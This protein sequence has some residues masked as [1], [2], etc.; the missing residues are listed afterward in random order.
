MIFFL[1]LS[2]QESKEDSTGNPSQEPSAE[3]SSVGDTGVEDTGFADTGL[4]DTGEEDTGEED[5]SGEDASLPGCDGIVGSGKEYDD[6]GVCG[7]ESSACHVATVLGRVTPADFDSDNDIYECMDEN[8]SDSWFACNRD[9]QYDGC[10]VPGR[11]LN[12]GESWWNEFPASTDPIDA[13]LACQ[14]IF[15]EL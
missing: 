11:E 10:P 12:W 7:G 15:G 1:L 8:N 2:C 14:T 3:P 9:R 4:E 13:L 6:C 5:T